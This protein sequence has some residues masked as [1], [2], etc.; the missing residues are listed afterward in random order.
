MQI[1]FLIKTKR[2]SRLLQQNTA[3][4]DQKRQKTTLSNSTLLRKDL[5]FIESKPMFFKVHACT[6][7]FPNAG[8]VI[9]R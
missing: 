3:R 4:I 2:V 8:H 5:T 1:G 7:C 6:F 9:T